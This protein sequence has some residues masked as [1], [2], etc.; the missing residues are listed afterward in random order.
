MFDEKLK[1]PLFDTYKFS[2]HDSNKFILFSRKGVYPYEYIDDWGKFDETL[3]PEKG[4]IYNNLNM[5]YI[6]D[7]YYLDVKRDCKDFEIKH[8]GEYHD[9][10]VQSD[11]LLLVDVFENFRNMCLKTYNLIL[12]VF[13]HF[14][15]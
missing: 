6:I 4:D 8:L 12:H 2:N 11:T 3:L 13:F 10:C 5:E 14:L 7:A 9:L 15:D 1:K